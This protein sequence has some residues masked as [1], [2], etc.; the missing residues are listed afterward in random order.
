MT[1]IESDR[2]LS[3]FD[4]SRI[5]TSEEVLTE[6]SPKVW[7][8]SQVNRAVYG[9]L[10]SSVDQLWVSGEVSRWTRSRAG[11]CYF[12]LKDERAQIRCA[13]FSREADQLPANPEE[14]T[15]IRVF[16]RVTLY[17]ARGEYQLVVRRLEP[18]GEEGLWR[19][20][21]E[22]LRHRLDIEGLL[23]D[24]RKRALPRYPGC[25]GI[26]TSRKGA[27][28]ADILKALRRRAPWTQVLIR[29]TRVQGEGAALQIAEA[30][31]QLV[32]TTLPDV[33]ILGRGG[34]SVEDLWAF[35]EEPVAR[36]IATSPVPIV[37]AVGHEIDV[38]IS[39][40]VADYR[41]ATPSSAVEAAVPD[42]RVLAERL[43]QAGGQLG[44]TLRRV[45]EGQRFFVTEGRRRLQV[46]I[47]R[48][49]TPARQGLDR[50]CK[51]LEA[52]ANHLTNRQRMKF[53]GLV[54]RL[55]ALSPLATLGRGYSVARSMD[56]RV[57]KSTLDF[58]QGSV[59][60]LQ[61]TDGKLLAETL[62]AGE[63]DGKDE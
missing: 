36:A 61:V 63:G 37:S 39:D 29:D 16:G 33:I 35:N 49:F 42:V 43:E 10:E 62:G 30:L 56:G 59:F 5:E 24:D 45:S 13:M 14:G 11:H 44:R 6:Q 21:F 9:L 15:K 57:L 8:V 28:L 2:G 48:Q 47:E 27:A 18:E 17:E 31:T 12:S 41:A 1:R 3:P 50:A 7:S 55:E 20:A 46:A 53:E 60:E 52:T 32:N 4:D 58:T 34:G 19:L 22:Q 51:Q 54:G 26:V 25:V 38:S 23:K 40:L